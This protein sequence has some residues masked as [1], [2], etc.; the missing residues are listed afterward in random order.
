MTECN[1]HNAENLTMLLKLVQRFITCRELIL[2]NPEELLNFLLTL[3][4]NN[5]IK[6]FINLH[7]IVIDIISHLLTD[8]KFSSKLKNCEN[9]FTKV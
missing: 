7:N 8:Q 6:D 9:I 5:Y 3:T 4:T 2:R 1:L